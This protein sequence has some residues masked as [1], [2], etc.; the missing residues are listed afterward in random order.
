MTIPWEIVRAKA[1]ADG[2][3]DEEAIREYGEVLK[4]LYYGGGNITD[5]VTVSA[6][7]GSDTSIT[8]TDP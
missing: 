2:R 4:S 8:P 3:L 1:I 5:G 7:E 6:T